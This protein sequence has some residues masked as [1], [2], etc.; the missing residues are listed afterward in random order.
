MQRYASHWVKDVE[1][2]SV[3]AIWASVF[4]LKI[5]HAQLVVECIYTTTVFGDEGA[6]FTLHFLAILLEAPKNFT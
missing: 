3:F 1:F 2:E 6:A 5:T 4:A